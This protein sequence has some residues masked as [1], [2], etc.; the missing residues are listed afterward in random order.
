VPAEFGPDHTLSPDEA[1][2]WRAIER[3]LRRDLP[4]RRIERRARLRSDRTLVLA[5]LVTVTGV[6]LGA[7]ALTCP[8]VLVSVAAVLTVAGLFVGVSRLTRM[9]LAARR[10]RRS[11]LWFPPH[12]RR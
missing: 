8:P 7:A 4:L 11:P 9:G 5:A 3:S 2:A 10:A 12:R 1:Y 6:L